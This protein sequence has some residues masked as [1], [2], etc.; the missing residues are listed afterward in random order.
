MNY[1]MI[2]NTVGKILC[3]EAALMV[4]AFFISLG[5]EEIDSMHG[6][7]MTI[8]LTAAVGV[9]LLTLIVPK[10]KNFYARE[11]FF[12]VAF[13]WVVI[14]LFGA[15]PFF[16][17]GAIPSFVDCWFETVSGF[18]TTG[19]SIIPDVLAIPKGLLYWR[20]F[21]HWL[22]GMGVLVFVLALQP[23]ARAGAARR[24]TSCAPKAP[25]RKWKSSRRACIRRRKFSTPSISA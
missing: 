14:S 10:N 22:G 2:L 4:P 3:L 23:M 11:G 24:C 7:A 8:V 13:T 5:N 15:L 12:T 6:L 20:S 16:F 17:S 25:A 1:K 18:T 19:A 9:L 21:T